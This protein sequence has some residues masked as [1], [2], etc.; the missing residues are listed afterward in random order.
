MDGQINS[1][2]DNVE[3]RKHLLP[4]TPLIPSSPRPLL[5][6]PS[7]LS[8]ESECMAAQ[9]YD[10]MSK[11]GWQVQWVFRY[12]PTQPSHYHSAVHEC[13]AVLSGTAT[14]RFGVAD[15]ASDLEESTHGSGKEDGGIELQARTGDVFVLPAGTAHKTFDTQPA[16]EFKLLTPGDGHH[17]AA[18][19]VRHALTNL[20]L[21]GF[22][23]IGAYPKDGGTWDFARGGENVGNYEQVWSVPKPENDPVLGKAEEGLCGQ[24]Q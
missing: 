7:F 22:T 12:G 13:M 3:V 17:I 2:H 14:I 5:H 21:S 1:F 19:D 15:T 6:Y 11:N 16:A 8:L 10:L 18:A 24:W 20:K 23:M 4:P 9:A